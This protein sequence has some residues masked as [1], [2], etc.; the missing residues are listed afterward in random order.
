M[1]WEG[2]FLF[3]SEVCRRLFL[4]LVCVT[5]MMTL[6]GYVRRLVIILFLNIIQLSRIRAFHTHD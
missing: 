6:A 1:L 4:D 3:L 2:L 5:I